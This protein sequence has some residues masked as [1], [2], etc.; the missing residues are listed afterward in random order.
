[1]IGAVLF[2]AFLAA[3]WAMLT[4]PRR[5]SDLLLSG[6]IAPESISRKSRVFT[7]GSRETKFRRR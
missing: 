5:P 2:D 3:E 7:R 1:M 4:S 6:I